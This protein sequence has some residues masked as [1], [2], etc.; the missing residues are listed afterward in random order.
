MQSLQIVISVSSVRSVAH[1]TSYEF[2]NLKNYEERKATNR[3]PDN[4][5]SS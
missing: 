4:L 2:I 5:R 1:C 3:E